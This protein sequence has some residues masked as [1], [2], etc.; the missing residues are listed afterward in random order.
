MKLLLA[1]D[2]ATY[3][4]LLRITLQKL[5]VVTAV[6]N[7][8]AAV[9]EV[10]KAR[11][12]DEP[13]GA[14]IFD[15]AMVGMGGLAA[16]QAIREQETASGIES[17]IRLALL[18]GHAQL[19]EEEQALLARYGIEYCWAKPNDALELRTAVACWLASPAPDKAA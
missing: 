13:F 4:E 6:A 1:E 10:E 12:S 7:G 19:L 8:A 11:L 18:T 5:Y 16:A 15:C 9:E 14:A 2:D 3:R 17:P